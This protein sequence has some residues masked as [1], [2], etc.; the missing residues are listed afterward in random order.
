[1]SISLR[2]LLEEWGLFDRMVSRSLGC[3]LREIPRSFHLP[4][5]SVTA[6]ITS[7]RSSSAASIC[8]CVM[9]DSGSDLSFQ[10][11]SINLASRQGWILPC[12]TRLGPVSADAR[13]TVS[14]LEFTLRTV[15]AAYMHI[16]CTLINI[17]HDGKLNCKFLMNPWQYKHGVCN[18]DNNDVCQFCK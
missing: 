8:I 10:I 7:R 14:L 2:Q 3:N 6:E 5:R 1:M 11:G 17:W 12:E 13:S 18:N 9:L 16:Y 4:V 15:K